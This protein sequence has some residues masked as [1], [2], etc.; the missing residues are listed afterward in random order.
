[1]NPK[2]K[3]STSRNIK[4]IAFDLN[5]TEELEKHPQISNVPFIPFIAIAII[6]TKS[7]NETINAEI[8]TKIPVTNKVPST[9]SAHGKNRANPS[10]MNSGRI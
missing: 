1:M 9:N 6:N 2:N 4:N 10:T 8:R 5:V 7:R 3:S